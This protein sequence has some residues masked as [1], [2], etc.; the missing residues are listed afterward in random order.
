MALLANLGI[1]AEEPEQAEANS[2]ENEQSRFFDAMHKKH[3]ESYR[4]ELPDRDTVLELQPEPVFSWLN[5]VRGG[6][7][8]GAI[9]VWTRE[10]RAEIIGCVFSQ[11]RLGQENT[12][13]VTH[14]FHSLVS[15]PVR[16]T[17]GGTVYWDTQ[18]P[19]IEPKPFADA[20]PPADSRARR[21]IQMRRLAR[22]F[23]GYSIDFED[24]RWTLELLPQP[25]H[26]TAEENPEVL[27]GALFTF[28]STSGTDPEALI[29]IEAR[30]MDGHAAWH[31]SVC[32]FTD[33]TT[34]VSLDGDV[35]WRF[36]NEAKTPFTDAGLR[37]E[38]RFF[39]AG[40]VQ[41]PVE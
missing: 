9:F 27:D 23:S 22:R 29:L 1:A 10:G 2:D 11:P 36:D 13:V 17:R 25:L 15:T 28:V 37:E 32:R 14:E 35:V 38:Y 31:Y 24:Q 40:L 33:L 16:A 41:P 21:L 34:R 39:G 5:P 26:R 19:G 3:A 30:E 4:I 6:G 12:F 8:R 20:R 18:N 7:Q